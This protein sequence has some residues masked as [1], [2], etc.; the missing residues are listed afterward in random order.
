[1]SNTLADPA[2]PLSARE[3]AAEVT[4]ALAQLTDE[5]RLAIVLVDLQGYSVEDAAG[6]LDIPIGTVKSRC[7]RGRAQLATLLRELAPESHRPGTPPHAGPSNVHQP[8]AAP[9]TPEGDPATP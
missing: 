8:T 3:T 5:Q 6:V 9:P 7:H 1:M 2:D 4:R